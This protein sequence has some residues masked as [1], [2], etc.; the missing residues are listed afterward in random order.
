MAPIDIHQHLLNIYKCCNWQRP[1][2][3]PSPTIHPSPIVLTKA[4]PSTQLPNVAGEA[5]LQQDSTRSYTTLKTMEHIANVG[6]TVLPHPLYSPGLA[7]FDFH[8][9]RPMTDGL[10]GQ[11]LSSINTIIKAV[12]QSVTSTGA[13]F[14]DCSMQALVHC[15][16][17]CTANGV[18]C[19][20]KQYFV[21]EN[22][23]YQT[24]LLCSLY[25]LSFPGK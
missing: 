16:Q 19:V 24:V 15:W 5:R 6:W 18:D 8:L 22:F 3:S 9:F 4:C 10:C 1:T 12:E 7:L 25:L 11:H 13:D 2:G 17:K 21:A 20:V 23:L 14:Y